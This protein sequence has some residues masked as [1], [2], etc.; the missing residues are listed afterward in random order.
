[1]SH[2]AHARLETYL[3]PA[4]YLARERS[5][6]AKSEYLD[7]DVVAMPGSSREHNLIVTNLVAELRQQLKGRPD[8]V[9]P[10]DL[11]IWIPENRKYTYPDVSVVRGAP[12]L[13][14]RFHDTL[15][16]PTVIFEVLSP[17]TESYDRGKK[18]EHYQ[19]IPSLMEY[20]LVGQL[21]WRVE[22]YSRQRDGSWL[23]SETTGS[24]GG[25]SL[26]SIDC[27]LAM[28]EIYDKVPVR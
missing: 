11:R 1:M 19:S 5:A 26:D 18:F 9:Y 17:G 7:G 2:P 22:Q 4:E 3:T 24:T 16:N 25:I 12:S 14:D 13:Q 15:L 21:E 8:E 27:R 28:A 23:L 20:V 6:E 10:S